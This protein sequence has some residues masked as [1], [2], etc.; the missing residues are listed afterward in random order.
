MRW[1]KTT[2]GD[3]RNM[4]SDGQVTV[5]CTVSNTGDG[6]G[7]EIVQLK[8]ISILRPNKFARYKR[9]S[10]LEKELLHFKF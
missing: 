5:F 1:A 4:E 9:N 2:E 8:T 3:C 6:V 10:K 7:D